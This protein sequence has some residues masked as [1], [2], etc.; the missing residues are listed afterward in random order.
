MP[1]ATKDAFDR[2]N[3]VRNDFAH[4]FGHPFSLADALALARELEGQGI[5]FSDFAGHYSE[6]EATAYYGSTE[7]ILSEI[8]WCLLSHAGFLLEQAGGRDVF[9]GVPS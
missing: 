9:S 1:P 3:D 2:F 4:Q 8:G 5:D 6:V 7:G